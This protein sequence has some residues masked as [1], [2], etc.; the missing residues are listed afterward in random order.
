MSPLRLRAVFAVRLPVTV[1]ELATTSLPSHVFSS[2]LI[3]PAPGTT[4]VVFV[5]LTVAAVTVP[6]VTLSRFTTPLEVIVLMLFSVVTL[7]RVSSFLAAEM[8]KS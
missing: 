1:T 3:A 7:L 6:T 2:S 4:L 5:T 8:L